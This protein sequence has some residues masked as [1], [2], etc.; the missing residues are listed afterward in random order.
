MEYVFKIDGM[1][2]QF[3]NVR[4]NTIN[5]LGQKLNT[6]IPLKNENVLPSFLLDDCFIINMFRIT[7]PLSIFLMSF[8]FLS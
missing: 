5:S 6:F 8:F 3:Y 1:F 7:L 4:I 2:Y